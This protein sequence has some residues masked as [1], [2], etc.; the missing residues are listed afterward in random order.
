MILW[1]NKEGIETWK[2]LRQSQSTEGVMKRE[3]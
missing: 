1:E 3:A 2:S